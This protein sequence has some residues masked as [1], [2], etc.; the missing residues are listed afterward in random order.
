MLLFEVGSILERV[1][2]MA[3]HLSEFN[4]SSF[5]GISDLKLINLKDINIITGDNNTGKTSVLE[6]LNYLEAP[7][8]LRT[9][10][11]G[12]KRK[13]VTPFHIS[14][15]DRLK[16][17]F[18]ITDTDTKQIEFSFCLNHQTNKITMQKKEEIVTLSYSEYKELEKNEKGSTIYV[19]HENKL[20][21]IDI[22]YIN[23]QISSNDKEIL[24]K[25]FYEFSRTSYNVKS[26]LHY[27]KT[28]YISPFQHVESTN[29]LNS[30][31]NDPILYEELLE[32]LKEFDK[33]I[34]SINVERKEHSSIYNILSK[35]HHQA[36]PLDYYGDG[37]KKAILL[38]SAVIKAKNGILLLDEFETAIHTSAMDHVFAWILKTCMKLNVQLFLTTHSDEAILKVLKA[39]PELKDNIMQY[40]LYNKQ[41]KSFVRSLTCEE[42]LKAREDF[43][44]ELR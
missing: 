42:A 21:T 9:L 39:C 27:I 16:Y 33:G 14:E 29:Y 13:P 24:N 22:D 18:P 37:M 38:M 11:Y 44:L 26:K 6:L 15:Y 30:I 7:D 5:R 41:G 28:I 31:F 34:I 25:N 23:F 32:I 35:E 40:T 12:T 43:D 20:D 10:L 19:D 36:I 8:D 1:R 3:R 17:L 4:I 2:Y